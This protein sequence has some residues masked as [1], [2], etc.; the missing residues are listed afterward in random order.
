MKGLVQVLVPGRFLVDLF[1][2][3][4]YHYSIIFTKQNPD[5]T[6]VKHVPSWFPGAGFKTIAAELGKM[7]T[8]MKNLPFEHVKKEM[9]YKVFFWHRGTF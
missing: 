9:V 7:S 6:P 8:E 4:S 3:C 1:P 2:I 5:Y